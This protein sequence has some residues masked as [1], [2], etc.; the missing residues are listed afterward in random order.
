MLISKDDNL[1]CRYAEHILLSCFPKEE[2]R[3]VAGTVGDPLDKE[4]KWCRPEYLVSFLSPWIIPAELLQTARTAAINFHP[5]SPDYPG[6]GCYNF[7]LY[8]NAARYGVTCHH[9]QPKVDSGDIVMTSYFDVGEWDTVETLKLKSMNHLLLCFE[10]V[11]SLIAAG[12]PLPL[13]EEKWRRKPFTRKEMYQLFEIDPAACDTA[14]VQKRIRAAAYPSCKGAYTVI[15]DT[16]FYV[17]T[18]DRPP[19]V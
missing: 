8:E 4:L 1:F 11:V 17:D 19:I 10:R 3:L 13:S 12:R 7:A 16:R 14:E 15:G 2:V 6:S 9:M 18:E 5:G